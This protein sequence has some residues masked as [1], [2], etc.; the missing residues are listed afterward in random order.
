MQAVID[1]ADAVREM[2][3]MIASLDSS[4]PL[5]SMI[6]MRA[7][8]ADYTDASATWYVEAALIDVENDAY[9]IVAGWNHEVAEYARETSA[10]SA[11]AATF[12]VTWY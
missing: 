1:M 2:R 12:G 3:E 10:R 6:A 7:L 4:Q 11:D 8:V 5:Y 9:D